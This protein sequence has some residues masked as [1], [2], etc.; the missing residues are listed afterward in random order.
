MDRRRL[1]QGPRRF[2][3]AAD[4]VR[5]ERAHHRRGCRVDRGTN[6]RV[7]APLTLRSSSPGYL[8]NEAMRLRR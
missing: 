2:V 7:P 6:A 3:A 5:H 1:V 8:R 4:P